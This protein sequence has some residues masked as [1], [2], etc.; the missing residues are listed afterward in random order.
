MN[1]SRDTQTTAGL[2]VLQPWLNEEVG[3]RLNP[4]K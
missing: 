3:Q 1:M 4:V 2:S